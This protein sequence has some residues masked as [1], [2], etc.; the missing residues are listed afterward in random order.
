MSIWPR[1]LAGGA[2]AIHAPGDI[3]TDAPRRQRLALVKD[4]QEGAQGRA[5]DFSGPTRPK[6]T[7]G[8]A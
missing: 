6:A 7:R 2:I 4:P 8:G 1:L 5:G 3:R